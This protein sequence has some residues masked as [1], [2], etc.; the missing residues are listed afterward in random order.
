RLEAELSA[1]IPQP[2]PESA[3]SGKKNSRTA[4]AAAA[5]AATPEADTRMS[6]RGALRRLFALAWGPIGQAGIVLVLLVFILL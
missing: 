6:V 4:A 2:V 3:R 5:A 1:V